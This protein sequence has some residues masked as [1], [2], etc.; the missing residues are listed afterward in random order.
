VC[1]TK[2]TT[3]KEI[4]VL[5]LQINK[6]ISADQR[7]DTFW[8]HHVYIIK[9]IHQ[10]FTLLIITSTIS[11]FPVNRAFL[12]I[13]CLILQL[14]LYLLRSAQ[15]NTLNKWAEHSKLDIK[16]IYEPSDQINTTMPNTSWK[17]L[18]PTVL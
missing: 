16:Y 10:Y 6:C 4:K 18:T 3:L 8:T 14:L 5:Y 1:I 2:E 12:I 11:R 13:Q 17:L 9:K 15:T 7:F